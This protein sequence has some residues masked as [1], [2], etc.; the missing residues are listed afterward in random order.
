M[1]GERKV[2]LR[3]TDRA[4]TFVERFKASSNLKSPIL[5]IGWGRF[6]RESEERWSIGLYD[7]SDLREGW[8]GIA[9]D[10]D[11]IVIQEWILD[12]VDNKVLDIDGKKGVAT[13]EP[14]PEKS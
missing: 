5:S 11:F 6:G 10:F 12:A 1:F 3:L 8:R 7:R 2:N 14:Q 9:P 13:V 4:R